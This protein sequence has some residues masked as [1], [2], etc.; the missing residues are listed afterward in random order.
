VDTGSTEGLI[1]HVPFVKKYGLHSEAQTMS[2]TAYGG[3]YNVTPGLIPALLLNDLRV[4]DLH[5]LYDVNPVGMA[6][7]ERIDGEIGYKILSRFRIF[8]DAPHHV[9]IFEPT[10]R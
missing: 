10:A 1:L 5:T 9:V 2:R 3:T 4:E 8:V 7:S 6:G